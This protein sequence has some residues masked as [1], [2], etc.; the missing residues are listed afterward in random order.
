MKYLARRF[1][2]KNI[3]SPPARG[4]GI[5]IAMVLAPGFDELVAPRP[6]GGD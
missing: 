2:D 5:E 1:V 6:G 3:W 4:A